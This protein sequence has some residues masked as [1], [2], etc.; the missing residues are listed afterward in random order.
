MIKIGAELR[1][2]SNEEE[3]EEDWE[4]ESEEELES[5]SPN[6]RMRYSDLQLLVF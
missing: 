4:E 3:S 5:I 6:K 2:Q 1:I